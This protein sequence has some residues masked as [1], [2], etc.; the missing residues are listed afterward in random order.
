MQDWKMYMKI[1]CRRYTHQKIA[2]RE[3]KQ[4][5]SKKFNKI[6]WKFNTMDNK[7]YQQFCLI[8]YDHTGF[9][10]IHIWLIP[11]RYITTSTITISESTLK[12]WDA[13]KLHITGIS[14]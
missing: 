14:E 9:L 5:S 2:I 12:K 6:S 3:S 10:P 1:Y 13:Y 7:E 8:A 4:R 11:T